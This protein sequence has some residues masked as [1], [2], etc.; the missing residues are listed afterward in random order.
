MGTKRID[1]ATDKNE[2]YILKLDTAGT[3]VWIK[4]YGGDKSIQGNSICQA[5]GGNFLIAGS[6]KEGSG[7][8]A[9]AWV[10]MIRANGDTV[11]TRRYGGASADVAYCIRPTSDRGY[12]L[13]GFNS[14]PGVG[15]GDQVYLVKLDVKGQFEWEKNFGDQ[16]QNHGYWVEETSDGGYIISG[17]TY[18]SYTGNSDWL[19]LKTNAEGDSLWS[20]IFG[21]EEDDVAWRVLEDHV[22]NR[23][24][25]VGDYV[26]PV[27]TGE[28]EY[29]YY[30]PFSIACLELDGSFLWSRNHGIY[31]PHNARAA[32][33]NQRGNLMVGGTT[34][35]PDWT[36]SRIFLYEIDPADGDSIWMGTFE[37]NEEET[38]SSFIQD[39][40]FG[41]LISGKA[42]AW[43][44]N[45]PVY[46]K[47]LK[48]SGNVTSLTRMKLDAAL[49]LLGAENEDL[50][51]V[52][53]N[54]DKIFGL[55]V[56]IDTLKHP[57]VGNLEIFLEYAGKSALLVDRP[58]NSGED[59]IGTV[60]FDGAERFASV[61]SAPYSGFFKP[62]Q[63]LSVFEGLDPNGDWKLRIVDHGASLK[64]G[65]KV[66][67]TWGLK[68]IVEEEQG[69][70]TGEGLVRQNFLLLP[71]YPNP[72]TD[73]TKIPFKLDKPAN[74]RIDIFD[75]GGK[76]VS[77]LINKAYAAGR[78]HLN[79]NTREQAP[80]TYFIRLE[81]GNNLEYRK[82]VKIN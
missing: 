79:W 67:D 20:Y 40:R 16:Y 13:T 27:Q 60:I 36:N 69:T 37:E 29:I 72:F 49:E 73:E 80:G 58:V 14:F 71:N 64:S 30:Y 17:R 32:T 54:Q 43:P 53:C 3:Q 66:L 62:V 11:W 75:A 81:S 12:I 33:I 23:Y 74:V 82:A 26:N 22:N 42:G 63:P 48:Y 1:A 39:S 76:L 15:K 61:G 7:A 5:H 46:V 18:R 52:S 25:V 65:E 68:F 4:S 35:D 47:R 31:Q 28:N 8:A 78:H 56:L 50:I 2:L 34:F 6:I 24:L 19:V 77:N 41:Y 55:T 21:M 70:F 9:D 10:A 45:L 51:T 38:F 59:F 57:A 44:D